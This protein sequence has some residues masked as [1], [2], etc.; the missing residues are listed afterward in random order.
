MGVNSGRSET[1]Q[2]VKVELA[3]KLS[4]GQPWGSIFLLVC[5]SY[6]DNKRIILC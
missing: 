4:S 6:F 2:L 5:L 1:I 3:E